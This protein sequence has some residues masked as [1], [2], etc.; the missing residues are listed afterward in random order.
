MQTKTRNSQSFLV[1]A[2][3]HTLGGLVV[4]A[5]FQFIMQLLGVGSFLINLISSV[6]FFSFIYFI[7]F[8]GITSYASSNARRATTKSSQYLAFSGY[9]LVE[10]LFFSPLIYVAYMAGILPIAI[11]A[12]AALFI[13]LTI[14]VLITG[15]DFSFLR[16]FI[17]YAS[18]LAFVIL[19]ASFIFP[20]LA[21]SS[22][23]SGFMILLAGSYI[24]FDT[25]KILYNY[26][27]DQYISAA[28]ALT[29]SIILLLWYVIRFFL[30]SSRN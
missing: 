6:N 5:I 23:F 25:S 1:K 29:S 18:I 4:F 22:I 12:T 21:A 10:A 11:A 3:T 24:L 16:G 2:Y 17:T 15:K 19:L 13:I 7:L 8:A 14:T 20:A 27:E 28:V 26:R 9:L 30:R